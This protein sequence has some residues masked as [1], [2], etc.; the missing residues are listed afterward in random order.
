MAIT[1]DIT[2]L[3]EEAKGVT[4]V[5]KYV[6]FVS[7]ILHCDFI[8]LALGPKGVTPLLLSHPPLVKVSQGTPDRVA[9]VPHHC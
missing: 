9:K 2:V 1:V 3:G 6:K 5:P 8:I 4:D 7:I